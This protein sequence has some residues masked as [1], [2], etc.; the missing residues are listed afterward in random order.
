MYGALLSAIVVTILNI[1]EIFQGGVGKNGSSVAVS[2][3]ICDIS[4][5]INASDPTRAQLKI[6]CLS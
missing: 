4:L 5:A 1:Y 3:F 6:C 2:V